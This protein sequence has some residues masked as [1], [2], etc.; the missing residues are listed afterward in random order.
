MKTYRRSPRP[1][2]DPCG[3]TSETRACTSR[4]SMHWAKAGE[5][6]FDVIAR[7]ES[8]VTG[9]YYWSTPVAQWKP[10]L[11]AVGALTGHRVL[12]IFRSFQY[13]GASLEDS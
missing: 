13:S 9:A 4:R 8:P 2:N 10:G 6:G 7:G 12:S 5:H 11:R 3:P 1:A